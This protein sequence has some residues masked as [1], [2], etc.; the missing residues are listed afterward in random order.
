MRD[1][2]CRLRLRRHQGQWDGKGKRGWAGT[3]IGVT[4]DLVVVRDR[5]PR[6][7]GVYVEQR[8]ESVGTTGSAVTCTSTGEQHERVSAHPTGNRHAHDERLRE[9]VNRAT[10]PEGAFVRT[11]HGWKIV[12]ALWHYAAEAI[13]G[14]QRP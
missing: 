10:L 1:E 7:G 2:V 13:P 3:G 8:G 9:I 4:T 12:N 11:R 6:S 5:Q 14:Y